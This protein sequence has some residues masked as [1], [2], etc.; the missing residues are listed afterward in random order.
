MVAPLGVRSVAISFIN[1]PYVWPCLSGAYVTPVMKEPD[2]AALFN[3][4]F[5]G[6]AVLRV[7]LCR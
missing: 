4:P 7:L 6:N 2:F 1:E 3:S 5:V